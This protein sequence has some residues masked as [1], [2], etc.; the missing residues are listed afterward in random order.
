MR[1]WIHQIPSNQAV[2]RNLLWNFWEPVPIPWHRYRNLHKP[3]YVSHVPSSWLVLALWHKR[4]KISSRHGK[5][6]SGDII[7]KE[8]ITY[9]RVTIPC[10]PQPSENRR[11]N[12]W[13]KRTAY[14]RFCCSQQF[15]TRLVFYCSTRG[16]WGREK[17][18]H[19]GE[20][21]WCTLCTCQVD[22]CGIHERQHD[23]VGWELDSTFI[24]A[25]ILLSLW[26]TNQ[27]E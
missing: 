26:H 10:K 15:L 17:K 1:S 9:R 21:Y 5:D 8:G 22:Y 25:N 20:R 3:S 11:G 2:I 7:Q 18:N 6:V 13:R 4:L 24:R 23:F 12:F 16:R 27:G 14:W 19:F